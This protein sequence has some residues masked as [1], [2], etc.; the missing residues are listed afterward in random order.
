[1]M[2]AR[3]QAELTAPVVTSF[4]DKRVHAENVR[5][6]RA[7]GGLLVDVFIATYAENAVLVTGLRALMSTDVYTNPNYATRI[8]LLNNNPKPLPERL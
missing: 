4:S 3:T 6:M 7:Q 2:D 5:R 1:M 8:H